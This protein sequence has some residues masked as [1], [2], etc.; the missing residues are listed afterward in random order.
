MY[1]TDW[2]K[3]IMKC[4]KTFRTRSF[5]EEIPDEIPDNGI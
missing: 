4:S 5:D 2:I 3:N 1:V